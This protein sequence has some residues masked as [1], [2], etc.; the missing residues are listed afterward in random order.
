[1]RRSRRCRLFKAAAL[2]KPLHDFDVYC[3][4]GR[5]VETAE[6][7][8]IGSF[9]RYIEAEVFI[10]AELLRFSRRGT[11]AGCFWGLDDERGHIRF[12]IH[13][14]RLTASTRDAV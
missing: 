4:R 13:S 6:R 8:L 3:V 7:E 14:T 11:D 5:G 2:I 9:V 12:W 1:M 10:H